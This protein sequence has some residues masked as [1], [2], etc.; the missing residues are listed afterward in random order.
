MEHE[1][2][3]STC[4]YWSDKADAEPCIL[5]HR[6]KKIYSYGY[7]FI[8]IIKL[9]VCMSWA[10]TPGPQFVSRTLLRLIINQDGQWPVKQA[11]VRLRE[12]HGEYLL[13]C[14]V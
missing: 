8:L 4:F 11:C 3:C 13:L 7:L 5:H 10:R 9:A 6:F 1:A 2:L 12:K 14:V